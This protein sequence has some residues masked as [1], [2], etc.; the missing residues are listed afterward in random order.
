HH[1][2]FVYD[3]GNN[4]AVSGNLTEKEEKVYACL[5]TR[6]KRLETILEECPLPF[7]EVLGILMDLEIKG[8]V[9]EATRNTYY[10]NR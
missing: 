6:P 8:L 1:S 2:A 4:H 5:D 7:S 10:V 9:V 3:P